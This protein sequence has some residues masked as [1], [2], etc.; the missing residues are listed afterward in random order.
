MNLQICGYKPSTFDV[1]AKV[2]DFV[3]LSLFYEGQRL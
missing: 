1:V 3:W 2:L